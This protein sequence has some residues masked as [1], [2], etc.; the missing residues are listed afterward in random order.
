M[1]E[2][3]YKNI[4]PFLKDL[5]KMQQAIYLACDASV[6]ADVSLKTSKAIT[7]IGRLVMDN[8]KLKSEVIKE[9]RIRIK[10]IIRVIKEIKESWEDLIGNSEERDAFGNVT[11]AEVDYD[12]FT[13]IV[14]SL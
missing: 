14:R 3:D 12:A 5:L 10:Q 1:N 8:N 6:A 13:K 9:I 11:I 2:Q 4:K 7:L